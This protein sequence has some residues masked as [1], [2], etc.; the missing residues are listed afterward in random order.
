MERYH[1]PTNG[2]HPWKVVIAG[3]C[4]LVAAVLVMTDVASAHVT[5]TGPIAGKPVLAEFH[6]AAP[7]YITEEFFVSGT[8][9]SY[10]SAGQLRKDGKW[11]VAPENTA[12]FTTR[13]VVVR[14][15]DPRKF[16]GTVVAE[17]LNVSEGTDLAGFWDNAHRELFRSGYAYVGVSAQQV[18]IEGGPSLQGGSPLGPPL[19]TA[20][21]ARYAQ[22]HHPGD[23]FAYDIYS[24]AGMAIRNANGVSLL[25]PLVVKRVLATGGSQSAIFLTTYVNAIDPIAR[26]YDGYLIDSRFGGAAAIDG[27]SVLATQ[28]MPATTKLRTDLRVP[29]I[30][31]ITETDLVGG[32]PFVG[33]FYARQPDTDRLRTWEIAGA[34][35]ADA[36]KFFV[37][38]IDSG[39]TPVAILA[40]AYTTAGARVKPLNLGPQDH[41][42]EL[43][44]LSSLNR[45]VRDGQAPPHAPGLK[46]IA[47][48]KPGA[49]PALVL[50]LNGNA[51]GGIRTPWV[52][53]PAARLSGL[54]G[55]PGPGFVVG[56]TELFDQATL[57]RLYP[58]GKPEYLR[59]FDRSLNSAIK[60]GFILPADATEI[61][62]LAAAMYRGLR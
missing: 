59:R 5:I 23:A 24:Q 36:Y 48:H 1:V 56:S 35:H 54:G 17:W 9:T 33:F 15:S 47:G 62:G 39:A 19:K 53:V 52:D 31:L 6:P 25:G 3:I 21:P 16:N 44:A 60:S 8:A 27:S 20:N 55:G 58:A 26:A 40:A 4:R 49:L 30:T 37:A 13:I 11:Q 28:D 45:W 50:D 10:Q 32:G 61:R 34:A 29:V 42:V 57:D 46:V 18:G 22:L 38:D 12:P 51:E 14:P 41:Y 2:R 7:G 43:A